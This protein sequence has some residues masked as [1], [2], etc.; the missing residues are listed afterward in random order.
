[1]NT[2]RYTRLAGIVT[3]PGGAY[4]VYNLRNEMPKWMGEGESKVLWKIESMFY[5]LREESH[6]YNMSNRYNGAGAA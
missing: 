5:P 4:A 1:M 6:P 3:V 2:I